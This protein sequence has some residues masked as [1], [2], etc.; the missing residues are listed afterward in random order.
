MSTTK[1][2][3]AYKGMPTPVKA[4]A[5]GKWDYKNVLVYTTENQD[6]SVNMSN[7][8]GLS[9]DFEKSY[10]SGDKVDFSN[11]V[12]PWKWDY[13][14]SLSTNRYCLMPV[15]TTY[16]NIVGLDY[17]YNFD[18]IGS[19]TIDNDTFVVSNFSSS[20]YLKLQNPFNPKNNTFEI[21][22]KIKTSSDVNTLQTIFHTRKNDDTNE[23]R[24]GFTFRIQNSHF[25]MAV[26]LAGS[27]WDFNSAGTYTL[28]ANT[29]YW[30][31]V[32]YDGTSYILAYSTDG[33]NYTNDITYTAGYITQ[34]LEKNLIGIYY[35]NKTD[36]GNVDIFMG[37]VDLSETYIK[38]N[39]ADFWVP[40]ITETAKQEI[41]AN[42]IGS[43]TISSSY[44]ASNF[45]SNN[46]LYYSTPI[47]IASSDTYEIN[48]KI[49]FTAPNGTWQ[50]IF[51]AESDMYL[52]LGVN[53]TGYLDANSGNGSTWNGAITGTT[54]LQ[55]NTNYYIKVV[56]ESGVKKVYLS[57]DGSTWNLEGTLNDTNSLPQ[58]GLLIGNNP[59][60]VQ[61]F[62]GSI[63]LKEISLKVNN[64]IVWSGT[65]TITESLPGCTYNF[66]D[67]GSAT[68]LNAFVVNNDESVI[69]TPDNSYT[70]GYLLGT[71]S[72]PE[73]ITYTY[74]D[75]VWTE[76]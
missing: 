74:N 70:N 40:T 6:I 13:S 44:V 48:A 30:I 39:G 42:I 43:P 54:K 21:V 72:I 52:A 63:D 1:S 60:H 46:Y 61:P 8:N 24:L 57:T 71:V 29:D 76:E 32:V 22:F 64:N 67:D 38:V 20:N 45:S 55:N 69:L 23:G 36:V 7:Y 34:D 68:T 11:T 59:A 18:V 75:G 3:K 2:F 4:R 47:T 66:T 19:P 16:D 65:T 33:I 56:R 58:K 31:K 10:Q 5:A 26:C 28:I 49:L 27:A 51:H 35:Y 15:G 17:V 41:N 50:G 53:G 37:S 62:T 25:N 9:M 12:L 73:H 14:T